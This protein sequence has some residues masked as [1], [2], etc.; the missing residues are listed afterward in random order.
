MKADSFVR[1]ARI[2]EM[3]GDGP[4]AVSANDL[5]VALIRTASG[6]HAFQGRC[7]HQGALLG[8]GEIE[9]GA[10]VCRNHRWRFALDSGE[11]LGGPDC[12]ASYPAIE[13]DGHVL[14]DV[15][16]SAT[17]ANAMKPKASRSLSSVPGPK[18]LPLLGNS[19]E[20]DATRLHLVIEDWSR[21]YG[22]T[23]QFR[24]GSRTIYATRDL[25]IIEEV[26]K[27]RPEMFRRSQRTDEALSE[28]GIKGVFNAEG[29][30]WRPQRKL[31]VAALAQRH[32]KELYPHIRTVAGRLKL[33]WEAAAASGEALDVVE[34]M[35][36]FTVDVTTLIAF[37]HDSNTI[38]KPGDR[39][40]DQLAIVLPTIARRTVS[41]FP[42][43]RYVRL[44][45]DRQ[46]E[47][48]L[49]SVRQWLQT[50]VAETR[51]RLAKEPDR[52]A[53]PA[54]FIEAMLVATDEDGKP[55]SEETII[56]N[57]FTMLLAGEDTTAFTLS[58]AVHELC[59][60]PEWRT[61]LRREADSVFG[62]AEVATDVDV[63]NRLPVANAVA[64]ETLRLRPAAVAIGATANLDTTLGD[65]FV[66]KG[67]T[68]LLLLRPNAVD[69]ARFANPNAFRPGRWLGEAK[70]PHDVSAY[71]PFG[72]GPR[73]CPGRSLALIEMKAVLSMLYKSFDVERVGDSKEVT[74]LF[75]FTMSPAGLRVRL[76]TRGS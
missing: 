20:L 47:H 8:E 67:T 33:R 13:R 37:G 5:D 66:P 56:S 40:Q 14:V 39:I 6:W 34:E 69:P 26:L 12:L 27:A 71:A 1:V 52:A 63:A 4:F 25:A 19:R 73:M 55:F 76:K 30:A 51:V 68:I 10:L 28:A 43:W 45:R 46:F 53:R 17:P 65:Y 36:R 15:S 42:I 7:P 58:W 59:D 57:L 61:E 3:T 54:N 38:E 44:P 29:D 24:A 60:S 41:P 74:E 31:A 23:F 11:R 72:S 62:A 22:P 49:G 2:D 18:G 16:G 35:K 75:G 50:L 48:A 9:G 32:L 21:S 70:G 64:S